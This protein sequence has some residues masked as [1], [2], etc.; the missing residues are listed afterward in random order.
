MVGLLGCFGSLA[1]LAGGQQGVGDGQLLFGGDGDDARDN[2][3]RKSVPFAPVADGRSRD[4]K[5]VR[6]FGGAAHVFNQLV[7][8]RDHAPYLFKPLE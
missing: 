4:S 1:G 5:N 2:P 6:R 7:Y 8:G 3:R